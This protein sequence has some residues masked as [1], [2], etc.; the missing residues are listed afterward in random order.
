MLAYS[1]SQSAIVALPHTPCLFGSV[2]R[3]WYVVC[4]EYCD[5]CSNRV[6]DEELYELLYYRREAGARNGLPAVVLKISHLVDEL[7]VVY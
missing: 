4:I 3:N 7:Q 1:Q 2:H 6:L 5:D